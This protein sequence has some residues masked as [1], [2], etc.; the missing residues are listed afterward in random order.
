MNVSRRKYYFQ[1]HCWFV[2]EPVGFTRSFLSAL[3]RQN[4]YFCLENILKGLKSLS[5]IFAEAFPIYFL[6]ISANNLYSCFDFLILLESHTFKY[7]SLYL[8][9]LTLLLFIIKFKT[10]VITERKEQNHIVLIINA[11]TTEATGGFQFSFCN[12]LMTKQS[13]Q[14]ATASFL[15]NKENPSLGSTFPKGAPSCYSFKEELAC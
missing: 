6:Y 12:T 5:C 9:Y 2:R 13:L 8:F 11:E 10:S 15:H 7:S 14:I 4:K 1:Y 3:S